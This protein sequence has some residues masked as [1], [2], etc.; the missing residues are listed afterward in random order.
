MTTTSEMEQRVTKLEKGFEELKEAIAGGIK[1]P[2]VLHIAKQLIKDMYDQTQGFGVIQRVKSLEDDRLTTMGKVEG[3][4]ILIK[5]EWSIIGGA[6]TVIIL[7][8]IKF[9]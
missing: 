1:E 3:A 6:V 7:K 9:I 4:R 8:L 5:I 2:G